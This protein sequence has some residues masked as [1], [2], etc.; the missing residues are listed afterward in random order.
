MKVFTVI[1]F[2]IFVI[3]LLLVNALCLIFSLNVLFNTGI[4][5]NFRTI[6]AAIF[7]MLFISPNGSHVSYVREKK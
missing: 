5:L 7:L 4:E 6:L 2:I 3:L 1:G